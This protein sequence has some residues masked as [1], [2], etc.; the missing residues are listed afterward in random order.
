LLNLIM[1]ENMKIYRRI[2]TWIL[3]LVLVA[4]T[5][6]VLI[7]AHSLIGPAKANEDWKTEV[8][9]EIESNKSALADSK[10]MPDIAKQEIEAQINVGEYRLA[11]NKAP[12]SRSLWDGVML[13]ANL[14]IF[15]TV[16]TVIIAADSVAGEF[17]GGTIKLLLIRPISRSK[18]LLSKYISTIIYSIF[19]LFILF[20]VAFLLSGIMNGFGDVGTPYIY[21]GSDSVVHEVNMASH[22][23]N[24]YGYESISLVMIVTLAFMLS[25]VFRSSSLAIGLSL[26][27]MFI[28]PTVAVFL[29]RYSWAKYYLFENTDLTQYL[30]ESPR[31]EGMTLQFSIIVL[32][33]Y[34]IIFN[35][36]S[37]T[38]FKKRDV[39]S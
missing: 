39:A 13:A 1:N 29:T 11:N 15:V 27:I 33:V 16:F 6:I 20:F 12:S 37:W 7:I 5:S 23:L 28:G 3:I 24:Q 9:K 19:L 35:A 8:S 2:R 32:L 25:T 14:I 17:S 38:I 10:G 34:F 21:A 31:I 30:T 36:L 26:G 4:I 18:I 22:V